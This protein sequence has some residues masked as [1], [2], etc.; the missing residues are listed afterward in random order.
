MEQPHVSGTWPLSNKPAFG[1]GFNRPESFVSATPPRNLH[2][3]SV[4]D[5]R[6]RGYCS[7]LFVLRPSVSP[8]G[9]VSVSAPRADGPVGNVD[10]V[11]ICTHLLGGL[12]FHS[13]MQSAAAAGRTTVESGCGGEVERTLP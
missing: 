4:A 11:G 1:D 2:P 13:G 5:E 12:S 9:F 10:N 8:R 3:P 6:V 7:I